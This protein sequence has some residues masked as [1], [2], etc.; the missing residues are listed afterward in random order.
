MTVPFSL[1]HHHKYQLNVIILNRFPREQI[2]ICQNTNCYPGEQY[3][4]FLS[5]QTNADGGLPTVTQQI[6]VDCNIHIFFLATKVAEGQ[7]LQINYVSLSF[8][9]LR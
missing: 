4:I 5:T 3:I 7:R 9:L 8:S 1:I 6:C 2:K